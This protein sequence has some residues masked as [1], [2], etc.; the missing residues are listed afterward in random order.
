[1]LVE[2][3]IQLARGGS[4][5][6]PNDGFNSIAHGVISTF[7]GLLIRSTEVA[8]YIWV[9]EHWCV[10]QLPWD[11]AWTWVLCLL[12]MDL[13]Y[14]WVHRFAHEVNLMWAGHQ[15]HH[16]SEDYNLS[17]ALRQSALQRYFSWV[18]YLP[19]AFFIPPSLFMVHAQLNLLYQFWIHTEMVDRLGPLEYILNTPSHHRVHHGRNP[20]CIDKNYA[21]V[22]IIWDR[23][24]G[25]FEPEGDKVVYGLVH[26][27]NTW[28]LIYGQLCHLQYVVVTV[29]QR[30]G[31][32]NKLSTVFKGPGWEPGKPRLGLHGDLPEVTYPAEKYDS[33]LPWWGNLYV[34]VHFALL[35]LANSLTTLH[36]KEM[37]AVNIVT[38]IVFCLFT[39]T[40][41]G[42]LFDNK[43]FAPAMEFLRCVVCLAVAQAFQPISMQLTWLT[44]VYA[45]YFLSAV[46]WGVVTLSKFQLR[47]HQKKVA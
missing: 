8:S 11:S 18:F 1:M 3:L 43:Q 7:H 42:A 24:F 26:P 6:R 30:E 31:W 12:G 25:T 33:G 45:L 37:G 4:L 17:T 38:F 40:S 44:P 21:G 20:Y 41:F 13:G 32:A 23:I 46:F 16:S 9:H 28:D 10:Y 14:Y 2:N 29:W 27:L 39:F 5:I 47:V 34:L 36:R 35:S 19:M 22:L 15:T